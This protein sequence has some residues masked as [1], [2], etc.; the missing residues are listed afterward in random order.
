MKVRKC[1]RAS[2]FALTLSLVAG[3]P[4]FASH[5]SGAKTVNFPNTFVMNGTT[6]AAGKYSV[7]W[8]THSP[9]AKVNFVRKHSVLVTTEAKVEKRSDA[10]SRNSVVYDTSSEGAWSIVEIRFAGSKNVIV[11]AH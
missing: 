10:Y 5:S 6:V 3:I 4:A 8:Q 11:F 7:Q 2:V 1:L 9:D